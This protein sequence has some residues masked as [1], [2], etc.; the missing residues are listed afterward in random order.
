MALI[1][2]L[3]SFSP[4]AVTSTI[5]TGPFKELSFIYFYNLCIQEE[6]FFL[7]GGGGGEHGGCT[8]KRIRKRT[9][10]KPAQRQQQQQSPS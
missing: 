6:T 2:I 5:Q 4:F 9:D 8:L 10:P 3:K 7:S 1:K